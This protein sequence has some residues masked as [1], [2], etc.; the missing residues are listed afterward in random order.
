MAKVSILVPLY[1]AES[2][3]GEC[4]RSLLGQSY[5]DCEFIFVD[6]ASRDCGLSALKKT[7]TEF[8]LRSAQVKIIEKKSNEG[9]AAARNTALDAA[10]GDFVLFVDADDWVDNH[11][12]ERLVERT[13]HT[14]ADI[15]N[16]WCVSVGSKG[17]LS[18]TPA[19]WLSGDQ[20]HLI[21]VVGQSHIVEN[22]LR[23]MLFRR[24]LF[25]EHNLR[26]TPRVDFGEDYSLLPQLL[27]YAQ[28]L[29]TLGEYLYFYRTANEGSYMNNIGERQVRNYIAAEAIVSS[30]VATLPPSRKLRRAQLLGKLNIE[31]WIY[32]RGIDPRLYH[33]E[34]FGAEELSSLRRYPA[35][36]LYAAAIKGGVKPIVWCASVAIN[37]PLYLRIRVH[38]RI[39]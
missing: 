17:Q 37:L 1:G 26:F 38:R 33:S 23:G 19:R 30:F 4:A 7:V 28:R 20:A 10:T 29:S 16:A 2:Y 11:I 13:E 22:H 9:V 14:S 6:D 12:V 5:R 27:Y 24:S 15:C 36:R 31:K 39:C 32:R 35:L 21:A 3:I 18:K 34:L 25:E 8:P